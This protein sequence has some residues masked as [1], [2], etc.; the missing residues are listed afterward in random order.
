MNTWK[1]FHTHSHFVST[2]STFAFL[3]ADSEHIFN[4]CFTQ[5]LNLQRV[6]IWWKK[7]RRSSV[8]ENCLRKLFL[9]PVEE[10]STPATRNLRGSADFSTAAGETVDGQVTRDADPYNTSWGH[11]EKHTHT[12]L[13]THAHTPTRT[14]SE[15]AYCERIIL[16]DPGDK[17]TQTCWAP[18]MKN[19]NE[20]VGFTGCSIHMVVLSSGEFPR[21][22]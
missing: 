19:D 2:R 6:S 15:E 12:R 16:Y 1:L 8:N 22:S 5:T 20:N 21:R 13:H 4:Y 7:Q 14:N 17:H 3:R 9:R 11:L 10:F 18:V